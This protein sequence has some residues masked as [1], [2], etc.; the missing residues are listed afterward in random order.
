MR[1]NNT[2]ELKDKLIKDLKREELKKQ[3]LQ[4]P[5]EKQKWFCL[6]NL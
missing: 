3:Y 4:I 6:K 1:I 5:L 2:K